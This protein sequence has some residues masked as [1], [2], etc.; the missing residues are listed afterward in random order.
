MLG[1]GLCADQR[2]GGTKPAGAGAVT[3][4][5]VCKLGVRQTV[6]RPWPAPSMLLAAQ[7]VDAAKRLIDRGVAADGSQG[8][9]GALP[10]HAHFFSAGDA[11]RHVRAGLYPLSGQLRQ[12][13]MEVP[14]QAAAAWLASRRVLLVQTGR[15]T[16]APAEGLEW[17]DGGLGDHLTSYDGQFRRAR[18]QATALDWIASGATASHGSDIEPCNHCRRLRIRNGCCALPAG[19]HRDR[20]L[21][22]ERALAAAV[23]VRRRAPR[24]AYCA[25]LKRTCAYCVALM[26]AARPLRGADQARAKA[27]SRPE[28][29]A[30]SSVAG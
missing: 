1:L 8:L 19:Q 15:M 3:G 21:P 27:A 16:L 17:V 20:G 11:A 22:E 30:P 5:G 9:R 10:A 23:S 6:R 2:R 14:V 12:A 7:D 25:A 18:G 29:T 26:R 24:R 28:R 13:G 4:L